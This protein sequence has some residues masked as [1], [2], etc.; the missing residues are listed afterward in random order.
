MATRA[1]IR[2]SPR[3]P[4]PSRRPP[5]TRPRWSRS[6][7]IAARRRRSPSSPTRPGLSPAPFDGSLVLAAPPLLGAFARL[8]GIR[9][10]APGRAPLDELLVERA[11]GDRPS[12]DNPYD[13]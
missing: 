12:R 6:H 5:S 10:N 7:S 3:S 1:S 11:L 13:G 8:Y 9:G 4:R 2:T